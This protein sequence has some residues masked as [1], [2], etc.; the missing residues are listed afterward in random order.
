M[1]ES[2]KKD[3]K[4]EVIVTALYERTLARQPRF[5]ELN[6]CRSYLNEVNNRQE[7]LEDI[8]WSLINSTEFLTKR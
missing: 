4:D 3:M 2:L 1:A 8:F 5:E 7:A 6:R